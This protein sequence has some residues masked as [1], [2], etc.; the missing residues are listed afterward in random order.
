MTFPLIGPEQDFALWSILIALAGFGFWCDRYPWGRKYSGVMLLITAAIVLANLKIIPTSAPA[1]D[2]VWHYLVPI[3]I[4][5][6][7]FEADLKRIVREAGPTLIAFVIGSAAVVAGAIIGVSLL[8]LGP[9]E[10]ELAGIFTGTYI[11]GS[12]NFAAV[13]EASGMQDGSMLAAAI[14]ADNV[15]TN[16]HFLLIIF[17]PGIAWLARRYPTHHMDNAAQFTAGSQ[18]NL[19]RIADLKIVGLLAALAL[20]FML[21]AIG[22]ALAKFAGTPQFSILV[23]TAL[24]LLFATFLPRHVQKL[25]GH[26][27]AGN[28]MMFIF[29]ASIGATAD[30][31]QLIEIGPVLFIFASFIIIVHLI[32]LFGAGKLLKL[33]LAE[34]AMASAA[35]IGGP[36]S[37]AA[38]A[39]AKGWRDLLIPG[40]LAGSFGYA[41][42]SFVG[43]SV[44]EWLR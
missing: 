18:E 27:E 6:L 17:M 24:T 3:A 43:V 40:V 39:S 2:A 25:S 1:Y 7:L 16:L 14:A 42:G 13:A 26:S 44:V 32:V 12:L 41:F 11:G 21:A 31:W 37:A 34:L 20:A 8:N 5:L 36:S 22:K 10:A 23:T 35:C 4:P 28:V 30:I 9:N 19:H 33:D 15:V 29:L 38:L